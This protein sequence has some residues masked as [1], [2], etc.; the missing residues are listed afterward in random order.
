MTTDSYDFGE[1]TGYED[2][3]DTDET[4]EETLDETPEEIDEAPDEDASADKG[5]KKTKAKSAGGGGISKQGA[6]KVAEK[7]VEIIEAQAADDSTLSTLAA[8]TGVSDD[9]VPTIVAHIMTN[10]PTEARSAVEGLTAIREAEG[11]ARAHKV[12]AMT[13]AHQRKAWSI[14]HHYGAVDRASLPKDTFAAAMG[15]AESIDRLSDDRV[16]ELE[17]AL[18]LMKKG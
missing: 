15:F 17:A 2:A 9:S 10:R 13:E 3:V 1:D 11:L 8:L 7:T 18:E 12:G 6:R 5:G 14:L 16:L 4:L